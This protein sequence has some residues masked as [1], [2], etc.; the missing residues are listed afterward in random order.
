[1]GPTHYFGFLQT[2]LASSTA[3]VSSNWTAL[4]SVEGSG[5]CLW[6][7]ATLLFWNIS[8]VEHW[9]ELVVPIQTTTATDVD[10]DQY[11]RVMLNN[12]QV[13]GQGRSRQKDKDE[14]W[15]G[16]MRSA[17]RRLK[18]MGFLNFSG[19]WDKLFVFGD[20]KKTGKWDRDKLNSSR[21]WVLSK[22]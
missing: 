7:S 8:R 9:T 13:S 3:S 11:V 18:P 10:T 12:F 22:V 14:Y 6:S 20:T 16:Q 19:V 1:M 17:Q 4:R 21:N 2:F 15:A 5:G